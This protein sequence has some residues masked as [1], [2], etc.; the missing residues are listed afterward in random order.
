MTDQTNTASNDNAGKGYNL[1]ITPKDGTIDTTPTASGTKKIKFRGTVKLRGQ[2]RERTVVAMGKAA[3]AIEGKIVAG[4]AVSLRVLFD[5]AP[6]SEEGKKGAEFLT[7]LG[8]PLPPK[9]KAA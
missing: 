4:E 8:L 6:S 9:Q 7:V 5:N 3:E 2:D 1:S